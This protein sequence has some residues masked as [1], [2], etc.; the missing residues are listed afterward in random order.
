MRQFLLVRT[1]VENDSVDVHFREATQLRTYFRITAG[2]V[3]R[4][5][6]SRRVLSLC[7]RMIR[8]ELT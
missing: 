2:E 8:L 3:W 1:D 7:F 4:S 5:A 6:I